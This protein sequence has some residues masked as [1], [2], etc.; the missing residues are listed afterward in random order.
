MLS[1]LEDT[2]GL[3]E[4][5]GFVRW[6]DPRYLMMLG[7]ELSAFDTRL[8]AGRSHRPRQ[9][10][11]LPLGSQLASAQATITGNSRRQKSPP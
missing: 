4:R 6:P 3:Y 8:Q 7:Q 10:S 5:V 11:A 1:A 2:Q 9:I